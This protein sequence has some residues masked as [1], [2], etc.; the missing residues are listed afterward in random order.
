MHSLIRRSICLGSLFPLLAGAGTSISLVPGWNLVGNS[1]SVAIQVASSLSDAKKIT[2]VWKWKNGKWAFYAPSMADPAAL[3]AYTQTKGYDVLTQIDPKEGFWVNASA[4]TVI[5]GNALGTPP[6]PGSVASTLMATDL[7]DGWNLV[8]SADNKNPS[9]IN[10]NLSP[11]LAAFGKTLVTAW[12]WDAA[13]SSWKFYAPALEAQGAAA[14]SNYISSKG[15]RSFAV[16]PAATDG[17]WVNVVTGTGPTATTQTPLNA[18]KAFISTLRSNAMALDAADL[19]LQ[20]ELQGVATDLENRM[21]PVVESNLE[22]LNLAWLAVQF[23]ND[24]VKNPNVRF[25]SGKTFYDNSNP[26]FQKYFGSCGV[27]SVITAD[28]FVLA[29]SKADSNYLSCRTEYFPIQV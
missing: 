24:V 8:T 10:T 15:Y 11:G 22:A 6:A 5:P 21:M 9:Q 2:S 1:D 3:A 19:S 12:G 16:A 4:S 13:T 20:T 28:H 14:L 18:A 17:F 7:A 25:V 23:W 26:Y 29:T 27:Y